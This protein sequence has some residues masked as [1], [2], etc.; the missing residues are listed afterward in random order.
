MNEGLTPVA[1][2]YVKAIWSASEWGASPATVTT[3]AQRF[4]IAP[5][6]VS[7]TLKRLVA[8]GLVVHEQYRPI[9]LTEAGRLEAV[10]MVRRHRLLETFLVERLGYRW[11]EVHDE[12]ERLEHVVSDAF[13]D[14][15]DALMHHPAEDPHG[16]PIPDREGQVAYPAGARPLTDAATGSFRIVRVSDADPERLV[17]LDALGLRPGRSLS[18]AEDGDE[19]DGRALELPEHLAR[20][21]LVVPE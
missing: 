18:R 11:D 16:D 12:A 10:R 6:T 14:R 1:E 5:A 21:I 7:I 8:R 3:L 2:D 20:D 4:G 15:I 19:I 9:R 13:L 17:E